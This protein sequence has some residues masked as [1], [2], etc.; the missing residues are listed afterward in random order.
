MK[1]TNKENN[2][3]NVFLIFHCLVFIFILNYDIA[4][5]VT[6]ELHRPCTRGFSTYFQDRLIHIIKIYVGVLRYTHQYKST[7]AMRGLYKVIYILL[8]TGLIMCTNI[9]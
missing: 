9:L 3:I 8:M 2:I 7:N 5:I 1:K 6:H 4:L